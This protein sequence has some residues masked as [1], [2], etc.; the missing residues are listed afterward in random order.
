MYIPMKYLL[1]YIFKLQTHG[2]IKASARVPGSFSAKFTL[3]KVVP[4]SVVGP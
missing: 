2:C 4:P 1:K 3:K